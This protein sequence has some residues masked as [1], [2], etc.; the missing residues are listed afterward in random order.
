MIKP[1]EETLSQPLRTPLAELSY[2]RKAL[3]I[4]G[5]GG[6]MEVNYWIIPETISGLSFMSKSPGKKNHNACQ[7]PFGGKKNHIRQG[8]RQGS[9]FV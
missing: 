3:G 2:S 4:N 6:E 7:I 5:A 9:V 1:R 8:H